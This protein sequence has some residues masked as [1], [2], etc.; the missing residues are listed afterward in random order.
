M[1]KILFYIPL[2]II[3]ISFAQESQEP[4]R[5]VKK[6]I[7]T[8]LV[9]Q[10]AFDNWIAG[11]TSNFSGTTGINFDLNYQKNDWTW[12]NKLLANFGLTKIKNQDV[13][14]SSDILE[15]NSVVGK[16]AS[17]DWYYSAFLNFK[18][19][20]A[21][22]LNGEREDLTKFF[23]PAYIQFGPGMLWKK[24]DNLKV[25]IAPLTS[26]FIIVDSS[27]TLANNAYFGV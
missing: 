1:K 11:G 26:R 18:T 27:L 21:G 7:V 13:Q 25:N 20:F 24:S 19:Q 3:Q 12:D 8:F 23:S 6:G 9:N 14:K 17:N 15:W 2:F 10:S 22:D 4:P 5:W 16:K